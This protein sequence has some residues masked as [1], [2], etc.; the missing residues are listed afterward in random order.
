VLPWGTTDYLALLG[1][2][3]D[4]GVPRRH[5]T[6]RLHVLIL[7]LAV[8]HQPH[9]SLVLLVVVPHTRRMPQT[10][11]IPAWAVPAPRQIA[12][13]HRIAYRS[14]ASRVAAT[15]DWVTSTYPSSDDAHDAMAA[16]K[17]DATYTTLAW[18]LGFGRIPPLRLPRRN[19]DGSTPT[20]EQLYAEN[21]AKVSG[22]PEERIAARAQAERDAALYRRLANLA[23][24][25]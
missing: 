17:D 1:V 25:H 7:P 2:L 3:L 8:S 24:G 14:G 23:D 10:A 13:C 21:L 12:D 22:E 9:Q 5:L 11:I 19:A 20:V 16:A 6:T 15:L 4:E 18:L